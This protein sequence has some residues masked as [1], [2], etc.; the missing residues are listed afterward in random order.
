[1]GIKNQRLFGSNYS[2]DKL[3]G[4]VWGYSSARFLLTA[5]TIEAKLWFN[6][7]REKGH[8]RSRK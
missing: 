5:V 4:Q 6:A 1:M 8:D 7:A 2:N 3:I